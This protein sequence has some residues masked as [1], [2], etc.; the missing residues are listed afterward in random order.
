MPDAPSLASVIRG[1]I[2]AHALELH[3]AM[4]GKVLSYDAAAQTADVQPVLRRPMRDVDGERVVEDLPVIP[5]VPVMFPRTA[6]A[7]ISLPV[8]AGDY[9]LLVL[10][11]GSIDAWRATGE[12]SDPGDER[13]H[14]LSHAVAIP[15][16][17]PQAGA[18]DD[19]HATNIVIGHDGAT[20]IHVQP[21]G[22]GGVLIG[23][24][25]ASEPMVLGT[26]LN[27]WLSTHTHPAPGGATS[28]P[29]EIPTLPNHLSN[30]HR[31][32]Q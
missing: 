5:N 12:V 7:F 13:R 14:N 32:D 18:L 8:A 26:A 27:T 29:T 30:R 3:T 31:V 2:E 10:C 19:A 23:G 20:Q 24:P 6:G 16:V 22:A 21:G 17:F 11:E 15:G 25:S 9:V 1:A 28:P 4:P